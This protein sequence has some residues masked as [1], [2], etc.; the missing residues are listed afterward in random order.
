[1]KKAKSARSAG[2][3]ITVSQTTINT[4]KNASIDITVDDKRVKIPVPSEVRA[5]FTE[6]FVRDTPT[7]QQRRKYA[8]VMTLLA[9]AYKAGRDGK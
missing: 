3:T 4:G 1:M 7:P 9:A 5:Y 2:I 6:Q 8:T